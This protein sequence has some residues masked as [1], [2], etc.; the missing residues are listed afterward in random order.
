LKFRID[1]GRVFPG[2]LLLLSG[3]V[4]LVI[5]VLIA[6]VAF[7]FSFVSG[8]EVVLEAALD[9]ML[10]PAFLI[11]AGIIAILTGVSWWG[12]GG[13]G[14]FSGIARARALEDRMKISARVG[15][16]VGVVIS[17]IIFLF[18]YENQLRGVPF[19]TSGFGDLAQLLFYGPLFTGMALS[20]ARAAYGRRNDL[21]PLDAANELFLAVAAFWLLSIF[22]FDF[23]H[24]GDMF[25]GSIQ[26]IFGLLTNEVGK[27]LFVI[28]GV[29]ALI[30]SVYT[31]SLYTGVR[32]QLL[33]LQGRRTG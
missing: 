21:R 5:L 17:V 27:F 15:E 30:N 16:V 23:G 24:F 11:A 20:L 22:P 31:L 19:F 12:K 29:G 6:A 10:L 8:A 9:L 18:L 28:A 1:F 3:L 25:P 14:W 4:L 2:L 26:F 7:L 32:G 33:D 13:V